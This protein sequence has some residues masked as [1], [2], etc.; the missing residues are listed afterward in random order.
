MTKGNIDTGIINSRISMIQENLDKLKELREMDKEVFL[1][2]YRNYNAAEN[3]LRRTLESI[4]DIGRH[5]LAK[6]N[7]LGVDFE[8]KTIAKKLVEK[9]VVSPSLQET[10]INMTGYRN[11]LTHFYHDVSY[12][13]IYQILQKHLVDIESFNKEI[14]RFIAKEWSSHG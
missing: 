4:F 5:I 6:I 14:L 12:D 9:K 10:L 3:L 13:E 7:S 8:Y 1:G 11:R 2:D